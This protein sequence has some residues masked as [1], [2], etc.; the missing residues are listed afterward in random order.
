MFEFWCEYDINP[1]IIFNQKGHIVYCNQEAEIFLSYVNKKEV[2]TLA[3][4]NAPKNPGMKVEFKKVVF[5]DF[6]FNGFMVGYQ[7][8]EHIGIRLFIN[9]NTHQIS[10]EELEKVDL[11][12]II[13]FA[14]EYV[15][16]RQDTKISLYYDT[17]IPEVY[18]NKKALLNLLFEIFENQKEIFIETK[19]EVGEYI[20]IDNKKYPIIEMIIKCEPQ[21]QIKSQFFEVINKEDG[22]II[23]L[24]LIKEAHENSN[25]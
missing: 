21:K 6:E 3:I 12:M 16:L 22:Y 11:A 7:D 5:K 14:I 24:P 19:I 20:K 25:S 13:N 2:F 23:K 1:L 9:T 15:S 10:L 4:N 8:D 17:S 18:L